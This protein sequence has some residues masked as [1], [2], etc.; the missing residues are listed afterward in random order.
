MGGGSSNSAWK[1]YVYNLKF[2]LDHNKKNILKSLPPIMF[3][4]EDFEG[5][6][7]SHNDPIVVKVEVANFL[8][9]KVLID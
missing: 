5:K 9:C 1:H 8:V 3:M 7:K 6:E 2:L 4:D